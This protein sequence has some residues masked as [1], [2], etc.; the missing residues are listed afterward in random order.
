LPSSGFALRAF[1][2][3]R[4]V[5]RATLTCP[6]CGGLS[7]GITARIVDRSPTAIEGIHHRFGI[8]VA[9]RPNKITTHVT[10]GCWSVLREASDRIGDP[11]H[12]IAGGLLE[13]VSRRRLDLV[14]RVLPTPIMPSRPA[15]ISSLL[16]PQ[17]MARM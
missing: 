15:P 11:P 4:C 7:I 2:R 10:D 9:P 16:S 12:R 17:L 3:I 13:M 6:R 1:R 8:S 14:E 5:A